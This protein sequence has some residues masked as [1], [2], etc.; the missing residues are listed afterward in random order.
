MKVELD[1][2]RLCEVVDRL[3]ALKRGNIYPFNRTDAVVPQTL[4]PDELRRDKEALALFYFF[5]CTHMRGGITSATVFRQYLRM[6]AAFPWM[7]QPKEVIK[8]EPEEI[9]RVIKGFVGWDSK[10]AGTFWWHNS[11][12]LAS[13]W[14]GSA[15]AIIKATRNY[16]DATRFYKNRR[17]KGD[18][19]VD[20]DTRNLGFW[21]HQPKMVSMQVYFAD[22]ERLYK[23][24]FPYPGPVDWHNIRIFVTLC[25]L[26][27]TKEDGEPPLRFNEELVRPLREGLMRYIKERKAD[28]IE[29][30]DV[31]W[32]FSLLMCGESPLTQTKAE[33]TFEDAPL[34]DGLSIDADW[35]VEQHGT[36]RKTG[37][38]KTCLVCAFNQ[39]CQFA[40]PARPYYS[41]GLIE[42]RP[43]PNLGLVR[44]EPKHIRLPEEP[45]AQTEPHSQ[46][47]LLFPEE[48]APPATSTQKAAAD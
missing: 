38:E 16:D 26:I 24:R 5:I 15:L 44:L 2:G 42:R 28:P 10:A 17:K 30:A 14:D 19:V 3:L 1:Y 32:L 13:G 48:E 6:K 34:F 23:K 22:W 47:A 18:K 43:M 31:N 35:K 8:R 12:L 46:A 11:R 7:F 36:K 27:V 21:G 20:I 40:M 37:L 25:V 4:V 39:E 45:S 9:P 29:V 41:Q 33:V